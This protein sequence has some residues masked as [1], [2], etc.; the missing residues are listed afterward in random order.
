MVSSSA[1]A[2]SVTAAQAQ[3]ALQLNVGTAPPV[4]IDNPRPKS[5][6]PVPTNQGGADIEKQTS[7]GTVPWPAVPSGVNP[8]DYSAVDHTSV[9]LGQPPLR[10]ANWDDGT[11]NIKLTSARST[12]PL[13]SD[14]PQELCGVEGNSVDKAWETTTGRPDT[15]IAVTD[16]GIEWCDT[17][18]VN[19]IYLNR[20]ALPLP[21]NSQGLTKP[22]LEAKGVHFADSDPYDLDGSG[23]LNVAQ[24]SGDPR[25]SKP[26]FC[27]NF[28]S[29]ED[30]IRTFG[31]S[32]SPHYY[33][34]TGPTGFT[35]AIA[36]WNFIDN[37]NNPYDDVLYGHGTGT[38]EDSTGAA[39]ALGKE[40]GTC[41]DCMV[42]PVR[43]G[44]SF[45][46]TGNDFARGVLFAV[47]SGASVIQEALG[48]ID[49]TTDSAQAID[50]ANDHGVPVIASAADEEAEHA[51]LPANLPGTI[52]VNSVTKTANED[53]VPLAAPIDYTNLNGCTNYGANIGV[54]VESDSCSSEATGKAGGITGLLES[55]AKNLLQQGKLAPYPG[56]T[57][58]SGQPVALSSTEVR[59]LIEMSADDIDF[60]T[61]APPVGPPDNYVVASP[62]PTTRYHTQPGYDMYTGYG[63]INAANIVEWLSE[64][65]IPPEASFGT[66]PW[67]QTYDPTDA[68]LNVTG[69]AAAVRTPGKAFHWELQYGIG[70]QPEPNAWHTL[71]TGSAIGS[72]S[73]SDALGSGILSHIASQLPP[74]SH[75]V[76]GTGVD[77]QP[78]SDSYA[79]TLRLV[80]VDDHGLVGMDRRTEY[81][82]HDPTLLTGAPV[83]PGGSIDA[84]PTLAPI[85]PHGENALIVATANGFIHAYEPVADPSHAGRYTLQDLPGW[86][87]ETL[88]LPDHLNEAAYTSGQVTAIPHNSIIGGVAV[89]DLTG[90][91]TLDVVASDVEGY[92]YA[93]NPQGKLLPGFPVHTDQVYAEPAAR[94][95]NN[96]LL[97]GI[98]GAPALAHLQ[99]STTLD[100]VVG[101]EDRHVYAF[102]PNGSDVP[103]WPVLVV[104]PAKV[105]SVN[106]IN[107]KVTFKP[108]SGAE[109]GTQIVDTPSIGAL[110]GSGAPDVVVGTDEEYAGPV[111]VS[112]ENAIN[113]AVGD[114][115][116][117]NAANSRV[118]ALRP[119]GAGSSGCAGSPA[120]PDAC[121]ILPGWPASIADYDAE[122]LPDVADGTTATPALADLNGKGQLEVGIM[123][124]VGPGY[125]L[126]PNGTSY[127]GTGIDGKPITLSMT[128]AGPLSNSPAL[129][130]IPSIGMPIFANLGSP[131]AP[132]ISFIVPATSLEKALDA[133][134]PDKQPLA[135][136]QVDAWNTSTGT[137]QAAFP[138]VMNDLQFIVQPI[139]ANVGGDNG[140]SYVV[141][142]SATSDIRAINALGR[143]APD[144]PK[145]TGG[146]MVN[147]PSFG[148]LGTLPNQVLVAGTRDGDLFVWTTPTTRCA[149]SGP[150]PRE[151][152][153]LY[154]T[155][156][157]D[158]TGA[159]SFSCSAANTSNE[160]GQGAGSSPPSSPAPLGP[161]H[162]PSPTSTSTSP[163]LRILTTPLKKLVSGLR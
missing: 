37:N 73:I 102:E 45:I 95:G 110:S 70:T 128:A 112:V 151:H 20:S 1:V 131:A 104:D 113:F 15:V 143:E 107:N 71:K 85:G 126:N 159:P 39:N 148:T 116:L 137:M 133:A 83:V 8:E 12:N 7:T 160:L 139:V 48:S 136:S 101:S 14:N 69:M 21:E 6:P 74:S 18:L 80:T 140:G 52:V 108:G 88:E 42:L 4:R 109:Q 106:P 64:D 145:F 161:L 79:F 51:N 155:D 119:T 75:N 36:G 29:A 44:E 35:E 13:V 156:N 144:F 47:D 41:P 59:E 92:I 130:S 43:V 76:G 150:W 103:G 152:H 162:P 91:G 17:S 96:R 141:E 32:S 22:Q 163:L 114:V 98:V 40:V 122:L 56:L 124:S 38:A 127:L 26:Y 60:Q 54:S 68:T 10:P 27:G 11:G 111:N 65:K 123:T 50:Y 121:A 87:V 117:L 33:G 138:Q 115:P 58:V 82:H 25:I 147:S 84:A 100:I 81:L 89:G 16:S 158:E 99:N 90:S 31:T 129:P 55:E 66:M 146:W 120:Q 53:N 9:G 3:P 149:S 157:L 142:G 57:T 19:K 78:D 93:W 34:H 5:C 86:P 105:Q 118:Y 2:L 77:G 62:V 97:P 46:A 125:I 132:G 153:D 23:V 30:L 94:D 24:Y 135:Q 49:E 154:N 67:F 61:A 72:T 28:M 63:R 134:L